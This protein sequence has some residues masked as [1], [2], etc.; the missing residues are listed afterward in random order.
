MLAWVKNKAGPQSVKETG[1]VVAKKLS[2]RG[3]KLRDE[4]CKTPRSERGSW[5]FEITMRKHFGLKKGGVIARG[6]F[7]VELLCDTILY[8][9]WKT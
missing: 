3:L 9:G 6:G 8:V 2:L 1:I 7:Q 4:S 5:R